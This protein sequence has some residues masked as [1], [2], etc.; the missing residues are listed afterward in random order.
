MRQE[1]HEWLTGKKI[2][3]EVRR[4]SEKYITREDFDLWAVGRAGKKTRHRD[5]LTVGQTAPG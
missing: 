2:N 3:H 5:T 1:L 4:K